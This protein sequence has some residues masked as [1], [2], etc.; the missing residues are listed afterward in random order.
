MNHP[1]NLGN[2]T[3]EVKDLYNESFQ[4]W[5]KENK[6]DTRRWACPMLMFTSV[7]LLSSHAD[8]HEESLIW[9]T[10]WC[11]LL[12]DHGSHLI[13]NIPLPFDVCQLKSPLYPTLPWMCM[14]AT[15]SSKANAQSSQK[16][17]NMLVF[18]SNCVVIWQN[19]PETGPH[20]KS[21]RVYYWG[22]VA[23]MSRHCHQQLR[24]IALVCSHH[25]LQHTAQEDKDPWL[26]F[27]TR[28]VAESTAMPWFVCMCAQLWLCYICLCACVEVSGCSDLSKNG[29]HRL[30]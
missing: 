3:K 24:E 9:L 15:Q 23:K 1:G 17:P 19:D 8:D 30:I 4:T 16:K 6:E 18:C 26:I 7:K 20:L 2:P 12:L 11:S 21:V 25:H 28:C 22:P 10:L 5:K 27:S 13:L 14:N 29:L